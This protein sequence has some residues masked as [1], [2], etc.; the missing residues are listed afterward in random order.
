MKIN[1]KVRLRNSAW[2]AAFLATIVA[3]VFNVMEMFGVAPQLTQDTVMQAINALLTILTAIGVVIDPTTPGTGDSD[4][5][6][7]YE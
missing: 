2:L 7:T 4:R 6:M 3:F 1:W 5:A